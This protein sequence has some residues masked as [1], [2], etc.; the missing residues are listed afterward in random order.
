MSPCTCRRRRGFTLIE[1]LVVIA[2]IAILIG[3]LLPAVQKVREAA[4]RTQCRNH[5]KQIALA[6]HNFHDVYGRF[7]DGG[8]NGSDTPASNPMATTYPT[9]RAEWSWTW[10]ILPFIEQDNLY[11]LADNGTN[12]NTIYRS[13][14]KIYYCPTRRS[15]QLYNN[16]GKID[17]AGNGGTSSG[18]P[19]GLLTRLGFDVVKM[20]SI[21]DGTSNTIMVG[22]KRMK[23]DKFGMS[24]D[25][26]EP[27]VAPGWDSEIVRFAASDLDKPCCGP[28]Q[29][30]Q[31][32]PT[33]P[34][35]D[36]D[37]GLAQFGSSHP[38]GINAALADGSVIGI[39]YNIT[40]NVMRR[41]CQRNDG[42]TF[43]HDE[44]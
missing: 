2:I 5:L 27:F 16:R 10:Q 9:G 22:E 11:R 24:Y 18:S 29:D 6:F 31:F 37:S 44:L 35:S 43:S 17:Y 41:V 26:N 23:R 25:D 1:L 7:P 19:N 38:S 28:N 13:A 4:A 42:A 20:A 40:P 36:P 34:F 8:K 12:N 15:A 32:T 3:L 30:I 21:T 33:P 39:R 14:I